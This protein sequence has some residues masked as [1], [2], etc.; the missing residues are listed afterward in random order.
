MKNVKKISYVLLLVVFFFVMNINVKAATMVLDKKEVKVGG[1]FTLTVSKTK[2]ESKYKLSYKDGLIQKIDFSENYGNV[3][4][5]IGDGTIK[6]KVNSTL[7]LTSNEVLTFNL[8]DI[9]GYD[10][11]EDIII[12]ILANK[13]ATTSS[14]TKKEEPSTKPSDNSSTTTTTTTTTVKKSSNANLKSLEVKTNKDEVVLLTPEFK[15]D[16]LEY[17][18]EVASEIESLIINPIMEDEKS[19]LI[20]GDTKLTAGENNK[21]TITVT[22]EDGTKKVYIINAKRSALESNATLKD[23]K[24]RENPNFEFDENKTKYSFKIDKEIDELTI[25][26]VLSEEKST[27]EITGNEN[28]ENGSII[29]ILVTAPDESKK[30]YTITVY[31]DIV[32]TTKTQIVSE[33]SEKNPLII[34]GLSMIAFILIGS[35]VYVIKK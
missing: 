9:N 17:N 23:L 33:S 12:T 7:N 14:T 15:T 18:L 35:I 30:E 2:Q 1:E 6:F 5:I 28:L 22:A 25:E 16:V 29:R 19:T 10:V 13:P 32:T 4:E 26:Y 3:S 27:V 24:I 20:V 8:K 34:M 31:K 21:I 11:T